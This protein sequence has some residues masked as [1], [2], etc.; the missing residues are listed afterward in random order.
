V[1]Q[2]EAD[3]TTRTQL[4]LLDIGAIGGTSYK[5]WKWIDVTSIDLN[6]QAPH[7]QKYDFFDFPLPGKDDK[8]Y[9]VVGCSLVLNF[10]GDL[11]KRGTHSRT[12]IN[13]VTLVC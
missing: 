2:I 9:D 11:K 3:P 6:P 12:I 10:V 5:D 1:W 8:L 13:Q 4:R 7:V